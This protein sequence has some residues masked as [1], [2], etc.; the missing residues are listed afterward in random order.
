VANKRK[1][2]SSEAV[3][4]GHAVSVK[5]SSKSP[6]EQWWGREGTGQILERLKKVQCLVCTLL[7]KILLRLLLVWLLLELLLR[8]LLVHGSLWASINRMW[9]PG[10]LTKHTHMSLATVRTIQTSAIWTI[11]PVTNVAGLDEVGTISV[12]LSFGTL[13]KPVIGRSTAETWLGRRCSATVRLSTLW[14]AGLVCF[15][16]GRLQHLKNLHQSQSFIE[17]A[18][19]HEVLFN[20]PKKR[21]GVHCWIYLVQLVGKIQS[22]GL[23]M[24]SMGISSL[25][26]SEG[27]LLEVEKNVGEVPGGWW[28]DLWGSSCVGKLVKSRTTN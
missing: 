17:V 12:V 4:D 25:V 15:C 10:G 3:E 1:P 8:L 26:V 20:V 28:F 18:R 19:R 6:E 16:D 23:N 5:V 22:D 27:V 21:C 2:G 9:V 11:K 13:A 24:N 14:D 7:P